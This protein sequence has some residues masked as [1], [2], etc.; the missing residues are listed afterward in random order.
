MQKHITQDDIYRFLKTINPPD[1]AMKMAVQVTPQDI[2][3]METYI[4][5]K[6]KTNY[7]F[8]YLD[9]ALLL[10]FTSL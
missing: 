3:Q 2:H 5:K 8:P 4:T 7:Y 6:Y 9:E 10:I 1:I